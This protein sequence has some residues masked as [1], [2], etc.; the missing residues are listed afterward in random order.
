M[1][2]TKCLLGF[3]ILHAKVHG[4]NVTRGAELPSLPF[5]AAVPKL[6]CLENGS[7][8]WGTLH[9]LKPSNVI[10]SKALKFPSLKVSHEAHLDVP[11]SQ[12]RYHKICTVNSA[13]LIDVSNFIGL[14]SE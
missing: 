9:L 8:G 6:L 1:H 3:L 2:I 13:F 10:L 7:W 11:S 12:N 14:N 4:Q 5:P